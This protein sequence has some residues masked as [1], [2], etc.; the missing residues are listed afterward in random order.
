MRHTAWVTHG[1]MILGRESVGY[2]VRKRLVTAS[3]VVQR[4]SGVRPL[5]KVKVL[6]GRFW[7]VTLQEASACRNAH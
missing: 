3:I 4:R 1:G 6:S 2:L 7:S 5:L